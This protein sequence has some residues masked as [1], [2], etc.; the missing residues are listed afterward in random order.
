MTFPR[1]IAT[2]PQQHA[3]ERRAQERARIETL[4]RSNAL[5]PQRVY[6]SRTETVTIPA[7]TP[8]WS[9]VATFPQITAGPGDHIELYVEAVIRPTSGGSN[10][11][12]V[13]LGSPTDIYGSWGGVSIMQETYITSGSARATAPGT[14][15]GTIPYGANSTGLGGPLMLVP[16]KGSPA[17]EGIKI[18]AANTYGASGTGGTVSIAFAYLT[19]F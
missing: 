10:G 11:I 12:T 16:T 19:V 9:L 13:M 3:A 2:T 17:T 18:Y 1:S 15:T 4:E 14:R 8:D 5:Q 7:G 6:L